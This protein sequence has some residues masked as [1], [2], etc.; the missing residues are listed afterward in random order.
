MY[1]GLTVRFGRRSLLYVLAAGAAL[2]LAPS[3][4]RA[5]VT[6]FGS[7][8]SVPATLD[9]AHDLNYAGTNTL[10]LPTAETPTGVYHT[11]HYGADTAIWNSAQGVG[12]PQASASGQA[13]TISLEGCAVPTA[14]GPPP[15]TQIHF[16]ALTPLPGGG[17]KVDVTSQP[18]DVPVCG[19]GGASGSTVTSYQPTNLCVHQGD[20]VDFNDEGGYVEHT[21]QNGV[22]YRV[23]GSVA[24]STAVSYIANGGTNN[25]AALTPSRTGTMDGWANNADKELMLQVTLGTGSDATPL[26]P[27]GTAGVKPPPPPPPA[28]SLKPQSDGV[29]HSRI[30]S[31]ALYCSVSPACSGNATLLFNGRRS[32]RANFTVSGPGT[33]HIPIRIT[34]ALMK[35]IRRTR[36]VSVTL[37]IVVAHKT[38]TQPIVIKIF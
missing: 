33:S 24:G 29:N 2:L 35:A 19:Q 20:Y 30:V 23:L 38:F 17:V 31:V 26:C 28:V 4:S 34:P 21:Y 11:Y 12:V 13:L 8:L 36:S 32:G 25:G 6:T 22:P 15:L 37:S 14:G 5:A 9:T 27:G 7:P 3:A 16:Q 1:S 10:I 18:F